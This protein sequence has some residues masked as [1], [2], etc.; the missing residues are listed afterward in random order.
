MQQFLNTLTP[1]QWLLVIGI[2]AQ[3]PHFVL[4]KLKLSQYIPKVRTALNY[5]ITV[6]VSVVIPLLTLL[7]TNTTV[8]S[9]I[10]AYLPA[11][12]AFFVGYQGIYLL[13]VRY[14][15]KNAALEAELAKL[16]N[17]TTEPAQLTTP[18][19]AEQNKY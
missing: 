4:D 6:L 11:L 5:A 18:L 15:R 2:V 12:G 13:V 1:D 16:W 7:A 9:V 19:P 17:Q 8:S 3:V 14:W 10:H